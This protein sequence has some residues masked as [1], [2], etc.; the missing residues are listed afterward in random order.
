M[1]WKIVPL[2]KAQSSVRIFSY[3]SMHIRAVLIGLSFHP[4]AAASRDSCSAT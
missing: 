2:T 1:F 4:S 3:T